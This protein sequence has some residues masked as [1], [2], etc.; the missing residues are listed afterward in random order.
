MQV[1]DGIDPKTVR[2]CGRLLVA[3]RGLGKLELLPNYLDQV[4]GLLEPI[5]R[6]LGS[7]PWV[8]KLAVIL[9]PVLV[10]AFSRHTITILAVLLLSAITL[11][12]LSAPALVATIVML[13]AYAGA[14]LAAA[15]G[16]SFR[17]R[18]RTQQSELETLKASLAELSDAEQRRFLAQLKS[19]GKP[20]PDE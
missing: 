8:A 18:Q 5:G 17:R 4:P 3:F 7:M 19:P 15:A 2:D 1:P 12:V 13:G 9:V 14:L 11:A 16:I 20:N 10:A 6:H